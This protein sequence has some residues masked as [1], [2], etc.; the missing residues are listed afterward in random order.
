M[1]NI[2]FCNQARNLIGIVVVLVIAGLLVGSYT[3]ILRATIEP[4]YAVEAGAFAPYVGECKDFC[5]GKVKEEPKG[6]TCLCNPTGWDKIED[7]IASI[8]NKIFYVVAFMLAPLMILIG[9]F[10]LMTAG[11]SPARSKKGRD[12][13]M[14]AV[15]GLAIVLFARAMLGIVKDVLGVKPTP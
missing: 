11:G 10:Y 12:F 8:T 6:V 13:I 5:D 2:I 15:I 4:V 7:I 1:K 3:P 9:A 14:Y